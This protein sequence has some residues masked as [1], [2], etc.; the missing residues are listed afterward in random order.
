MTTTLIWVALAVIRYWPVQS[1]TFYSWYWTEV[2]A[3]TDCRV[4][5]SMNCGCTTNRQHK[6][7]VS[8][9]AVDIEWQELAEILIVSAAIV[10]RDSHAASYASIRSLAPRRLYCVKL[11]PVPDLILHRLCLMRCGTTPH[12][13]VR[14]LFDKVVCVSHQL[15]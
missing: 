7:S 6:W 13:L 15:V 11:K 12:T 1:G 10:H 9:S 5:S 4:P 14:F 8:D 2:E 3:G